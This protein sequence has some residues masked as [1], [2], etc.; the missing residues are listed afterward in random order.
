MNQ[1]VCPPLPH[2]H[3]PFQSTSSTKW[4]L[5]LPLYRK[6]CEARY[7]HTHSHTHQ[8]RHWSQRRGSVALGKHLAVSENLWIYLLGYPKTK[9]SQIKSHLFWIHQTP[10]QHRSKAVFWKQSLDRVHILSKRLLIDLWS[11]PDPSSCSFILA[12]LF[13]S[14]KFVA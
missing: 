2:S 7:L 1:T 9:I 8:S 10:A 14:E 5:G 6:G 4:L 13:L 12:L 11:R 3:G